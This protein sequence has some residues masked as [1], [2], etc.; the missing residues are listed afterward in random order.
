MN[1]WDW[2]TFRGSAAALKWNRRDLP[3][4]LAAAAVVPQRRVAVQAGG[5]LGIFPKALAEI[6]ET[7]YTFEPAADLFE[8]LMHNAPE[9]NILKFQAALG[10]A[11]QMVGLSRVRRDGKPNPHEGITHVSGAGNIPTLRIDDLGLPVCD[12][13][14]LDLEGWELYA[15]RGGVETIARCR[16]VLALEVN[17]NLGYLGIEMEFMR[18]VVRDLGYRFMT[19]MHS[20]E[21]Y[22][23]AEWPVEAVA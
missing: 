18:D 3:D 6:F 22:V 4:L 10:D 2:S 17:K 12:L 8:H 5:H 14:Q 20:D 11:R 23:P 1:T 9:P 15:I 13:I 16:P 7:V 19:R 21:V